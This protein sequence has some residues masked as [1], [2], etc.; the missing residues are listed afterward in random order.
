VIATGVWL[1]IAPPA[2]VLPIDITVMAAPATA[3]NLA[4]AVVGRAQQVVSRYRDQ[5]S[6]PATLAEL[7]P[8]PEEIF[9]RMT[10]PTTFE[11]TATVGDTTLLLPVSIPRKGSPGFAIAQTSGFGP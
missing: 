1:F 9:Y 4:V 7:D 6:L 8:V 5:G 3:R 2:F 11:L 10:G